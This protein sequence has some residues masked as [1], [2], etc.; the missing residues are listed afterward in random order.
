MR[1]AGVEEDGGRA[2]VAWGV[3]EV[4]E[5]DERVGLNSACWSEGCSVVKV[6]GVNRNV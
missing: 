6:V 1:G 4:D 3:A 2:T 5:T